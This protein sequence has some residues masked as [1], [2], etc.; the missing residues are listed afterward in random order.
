MPKNNFKKEM[1]RHSYLELEEED[2]NRVCEKNTQLMK[3]MMEKEFRDYYDV[4]FPP[5]AGKREDKKE[6]GP[7]IFSEE[8]EINNEKPQSE[9]VRKL[10]RKISLKTHPDINDGKYKDEFME[11]KKSYEKKDVA[12][13]FK[14]A[15]LLGIDTPEPS[16]EM[17]E[18]LRVNNDSLQE[19][20][21]KR[22][23]TT[24]WL[25]ENLN[26]DD[27]KKALIKFILASYGVNLQG[28]H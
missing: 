7:E 18:A 24:A 28:E 16:T 23:N 13:L 21:A 8:I 14:I 10:F 25:W 15:S 3:E 22:K 17:V 2:V 6:T 9:E 5:N 1:F 12:K 26:T 4:L 19:K 20:I 11:A 27:D